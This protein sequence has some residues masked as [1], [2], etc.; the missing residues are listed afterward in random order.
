[1]SIGI[2]KITNKIN[3][4]I[5]I[6]QSVHIERRFSEHKVSSHNPKSLIHKALN[7]YGIEN[8]DFS[9]I[10]ECEENQLDE[11]EIF[12]IKYYNSLAPNG[13]NVQFGGSDTHIIPT[14]DVKMIQQLL[15]DKNC[16]TSL[17]QIAE[18]FDCSV[19]TIYRINQGE[20]YANKDLKY[21]LREKPSHDKKYWFCI[22]CGALI[23]KG[24][25]RCM[26]CA[27]QAQ[28]TVD[29]PDKDT[30]A[31]EIVQYGFEGVGRKYG[32]SGNAI[33]KWCDAYKIPRLKKE[34]V[35]YVKDNLS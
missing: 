21:P 35:Q 3:G 27:I 28:Y 22:D 7:E 6:G 5:Y 26:S 29:R 30:L 24:S 9:I 14:E 25:L 16:D 2:Y 33:K 15:L 17:R 32:V 4:K 19:R 23:T 1:M 31:K 34:L 10:D 8:F 12:Y 18:D 13:Y 20:V 11:K